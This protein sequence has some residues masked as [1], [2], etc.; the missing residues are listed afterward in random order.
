MKKT[1]SGLFIPDN[2]TFKDLLEILKDAALI[3]ETMVDLQTGNSDSP[4]R[5]AA[6]SNIE[7]IKKN[8]GRT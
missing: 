5:K 2:D 7:T 6:M 1:K 8:C 4:K 3:Q